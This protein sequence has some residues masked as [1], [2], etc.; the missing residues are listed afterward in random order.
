MLNIR[1]N[2]RHTATSLE[3]WLQRRLREAG[4]RFTLACECSGLSFF[5]PPGPFS[6]LVTRAI[7]AVTGRTPAL[8]T[9]G[10]TSDARFI[11]DV[12]PVLEFGLVGETAHKIDENVAVADLAGLSAIYARVLAAYFGVGG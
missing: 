5:C 7:E 2:D 9:S 8:S 3:K 10:G 11:K 1:F 12:C 6:S 4:E